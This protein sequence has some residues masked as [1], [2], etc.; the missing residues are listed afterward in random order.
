MELYREEKRLALVIRVSMVPEPADFDMKVRQKGLKHLAAKGIP[1]NAHL[2][3]NKK[4]RPF[5]RNCLDDLYEGY[6]GICAYLSIHFERVTGTA[7]TDHFVPQSAI[8][9]LAYE[10]S[11]YR[12]AS[13]AMNT[14]KGTCQSVLDPFKVKNDWFRLEL[15][16]GRT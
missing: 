11:N 3:S 8:P 15:L 2:P 5:W 6:D 9:G 1:L 12:L 10:W 7:S 4:I 14:K 13:M 16:T